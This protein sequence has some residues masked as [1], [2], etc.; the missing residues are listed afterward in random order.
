MQRML[1]KNIVI[2]TR[3]SPHRISFSMFMLTLRRRPLASLT[4]WRAEVG[5]LGR[6]RG[7][8]PKTHSSASLPMARTRRN[9]FLAGN[10]SVFQPDN[11]PET[12]AATTYYQ[13][14][15]SP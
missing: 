1:S 11:Q 9:G 14:L 15:G 13:V 4:H 2:L 6:R 10:V 12:H 7:P 8:S 5:I 3:R